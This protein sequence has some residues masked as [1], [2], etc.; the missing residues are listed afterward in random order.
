[1]ARY[2]NIEVSD[3][4]V[5]LFR[6]MHKVD[7]YREV[8]QTIQAVW[9]NLSLLGEMVGFGANIRDTRQS[10]YTLT[11]DLLN[12]L[13]LKTL[14]KRVF[15]MHAK[16]Q[17]VIDVLVRNLFERTA[18]V[19][20][21]ALDEDIKE[22]LQK[23]GNAA[24]KEVPIDDKQSLID[25]LKEYVAKH[26]VY[27]DIILLN[28]RGDVVARLDYSVDV[29]RTT[30]QSFFRALIN[31][32]Y[33]EHFGPIDLMEDQKSALLYMHPIQGNIGPLG[34]LC[35]SFHL[36]DEMRGIYKQLLDCQDW[37]IITLVDE[38][39]HVV[40]S[41]DPY[42]IPI[43][44][45][46]ID[47]KPHDYKVERFG[48]QEYITT[49]RPTRGYQGYYGPGWLGTVMVPL[50]YAFDDEHPNTE[51]IPDEI[52]ESIMRNSSHF[53]YELSHMSQKAA[54]LQ[55]DISRSVWNGN[56]RGA[57]NSDL[58]S[59][60]KTLLWETSKAGSKT[61]EIFSRPIHILQETAISSILADSQFQATFAIDL[62]DRN[63]YERANDCR[64]WALTSSFRRLLQEPKLTEQQ[65]EQISDIL[66]HINSLYTVYTNLFVFDRT[67]TII[68][69]SNPSERGF[70]G[71]RVREAW[72]SG[73]LQL[74]TSQ[75]YI[76]SDFTTTQYYNNNHT[77]IYGAA[78]KR[79][80]CSR[81]I[82][83]VGI[84]FDSEYQFRKILTEIL[85]VETNGAPRQDSFALFIQRD[86]KVIASSDDTYKPGEQ[87]LIFPEALKLEH[88]EAC[89][90]VIDFNG[91]YYAVGARMSSSYRE[92]KGEN[93]NYRNDVVAVV[94]S[95]LCHTDTEYKEL[96]QRLS[97]QSDRGSP[98]ELVELATFRVGSKWLGIETQYVVEALGKQ[99]IEY[100]NSRN[101]DL[102]GYIVFNHQLVP[103]FELY[104][105]L[106]L[107]LPSEQHDSD[108]QRQ[109][110]IVSNSQDEHYGLLV[111]SLG[112]IPE[113]LVSRLLTL[114]QPPEKNGPVQALLYVDNEHHQKILV[115]D[116][117]HLIELLSN[118][119]AV[120]HPIDEQE[121][122][123]LVQNMEEDVIIEEEVTS[124]DT[125]AEAT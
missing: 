91:Q 76:V 11:C 4:L 123:E 22:F 55:E 104:H 97:L 100:L 111:D 10:F 5:G 19:G 108:K 17:V 9:D 34:V 114:P 79:M 36:E 54:A 28:E 74:K 87:F 32:G 41:S 80:D 75:D 106:G 118:N 117:E 38:T 6:Y 112:E 98:N 25:R 109:V 82:G 15:E 46:P 105:I 121:L 26:S 64:W 45:T 56:I 13:A 116:P 62:M 44:S 103:V 37:A 94:F 125:L 49:T 107:P 99:A 110:V 18:D 57:Q 113:V 122:D 33:T 67:C 30:S 68:A 85:P 1:M 59:F 48:C 96:T 42:Q 86:G 43:G 72:A 88:G 73:A 70:V 12:Q 40:S 101:Q 50:N 78:I 60:S 27:S 8:L 81:N 31:T 120:Q 95:K 2:K 51:D 39:G 77:Y 66:T 14:E 24:P 90:Q 102:F 53:G 35:L 115:L 119:L 93:D 47:P 52:L 71:T 63:L 89:S 21:L 124:N 65:C 69:V 29:P 83:G 3:E 7:E 61:Q 16:S 20:F 92:Y 58:G 84:V 23:Y